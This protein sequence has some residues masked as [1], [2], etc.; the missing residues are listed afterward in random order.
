MPR[1]A[2]VPKKTGDIMKLLALAAA[3]AA[4]TTV[5]AAQTAPTMDPAVVELETASSDAGIIVPLLALLVFVAAL[6]G[7]KG[8]PVFID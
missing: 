3:F 2:R 4:G 5:A 6:S 8:T 7:S 1:P